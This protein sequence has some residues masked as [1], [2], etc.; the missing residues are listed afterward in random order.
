MPAAEALLLI[1]DVTSVTFADSFFL[2]VL[3]RLRKRRPLILAGPLPHQLEWLLEM[4]GALVL[5][6]IRDGQEPAP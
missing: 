4:T 1:V 6:T 5:F 2:N 3:I